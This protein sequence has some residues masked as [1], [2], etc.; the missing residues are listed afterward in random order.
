MSCHTQVQYV[1]I[2]SR[3][4]HSPQRQLQTASMVCL[5]RGSGALDQKTKAQTATKTHQETNQHRILKLFRIFT[6][7]NIDFVSLVWKGINQ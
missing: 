2:C 5:C 7:K 1:T 4:P 3:L 6:L